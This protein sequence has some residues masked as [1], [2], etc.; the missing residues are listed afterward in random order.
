MEIAPTFPIAP[1][2]SRAA[3]YVRTSMQFE[4]D[5][6]MSSSV[7]KPL[8]QSMAAEYNG[9]LSVKVFS[10][11]HRLIEMGGFGKVGRLVMA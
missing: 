8:K 10:G 9:E 4:N 1:A 11:Q 3:Q 5:G 7:L 2:P 6:S